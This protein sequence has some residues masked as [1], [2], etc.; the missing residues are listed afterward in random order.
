MT[1]E[2][3]E[4]AISITRKE[5]L[6]ARDRMLS[7]TR[8]TQQ[9]LLWVYNEKKDQLDS[10]LKQYEIATNLYICINNNRRQI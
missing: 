1:T 4:T 7:P 6:D 8:D 2:Q 3:L 5:L 10:L 9:E